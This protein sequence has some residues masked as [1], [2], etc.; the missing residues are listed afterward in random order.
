MAW[1]PLYQPQLPHTTCGSLAWAHCGHVE[2]GG[3]SRRQFD[4]L[5]VRL[6]IFDVFF[7][8]TAIGV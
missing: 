6:F 1:R 5:R 7:L 2:R 3:G 8:G 4:A